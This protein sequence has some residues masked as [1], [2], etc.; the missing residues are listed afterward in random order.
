LGARIVTRLDDEYPARLRELTLPPP[1]LYVRGSI[2]SA[3][4]LAI[5]GSRAC[6]DYGREAARFFAAQVAAHGVPV[7]SGFARGI[8]QLAHDAALEPPAG[9]TL[10]ALG[11]GLDV[12]YPGRS[13]RLADRIAARGALISEFPL[14]T[15]PHARNFPVRNRIIA[16]LAEATLVVEAAPRS[17]SLIT[18]RYA[19]ELGREIFAL[20]GRIF[21]E[22]ALGTNGLLRDGAAPALHPGDVLRA[23]GVAMPQ[24]DEDEPAPPLGDPAAAIWQALPRGKARDPETLAVELSLEMPTLLG[25]LLELELGGWV[26]RFPGPTFCRRSGGR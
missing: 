21:D 2:S 5:V 11:C 24:D 22:K 9:R 16:V 19:L 14:G 17:G 23:L 20:P 12:P 15:P 7:I 13:R 8:D 4:A 1:V 3:P 25:A 18:A 6:S 10:A 26:E